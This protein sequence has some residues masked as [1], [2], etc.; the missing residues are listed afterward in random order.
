MQIKKNYIIVTAASMRLNRMHRRLEGNVGK[1]DGGEG[2]TAPEKYAEI[3]PW[4]IVAWPRYSESQRRTIFSSRALIHT[5][6]CFPH[7]ELRISVN[8]ILV[9]QEFLYTFT[10][11][12]EVSLSDHTRAL[13]SLQTV[14]WC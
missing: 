4:E 7:V 9:V 5:L 14:K 2:V 8:K 1:Y 12:T 3:H 11:K 13:A 10:F 6:C